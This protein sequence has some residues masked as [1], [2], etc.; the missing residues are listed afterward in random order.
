MTNDEAKQRM[1]GLKQNGWTWALI[2]TATPNVVRIR[3]VGEYNE[4]IG[5]SI[6]APTFEESLVAAEEFVKNTAFHDYA[7]N[8]PEW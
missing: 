6:E 2:S 8:Y 7:V 3:L 4:L 5:K 1:D